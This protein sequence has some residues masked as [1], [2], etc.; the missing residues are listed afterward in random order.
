MISLTAEE[1]DV[2]LGRRLAPCPPITAGGTDGRV[3]HHLIT[4]EAGR[5][6]GIEYRY[7]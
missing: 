6:L 1:R 4:R 7:T 2:Q 3:V 5:S